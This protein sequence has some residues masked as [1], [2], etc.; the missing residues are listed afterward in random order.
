MS[1]TQQRPTNLVQVTEELEVLPAVPAKKKLARSG[2][3]RPKGAK[4]KHTAA[5]KEM[6]T[7]ALEKVGGEDYLVQ[8]AEQNPVAFMGLISKIIPSE[9]KNQL[10]GGFTV[11]VITG[12]PRE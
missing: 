12:V 10:E 2:M 7:G 11:Q 8:Q 4:N 1:K 9:L 3:G 6:I 5:I